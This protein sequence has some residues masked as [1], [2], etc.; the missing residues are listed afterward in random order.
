M[1]HRGYDVMI[2]FDR[3]FRYYLNVF[4]IKSYKKSTLMYT[5]L[6]PAVYN[7]ASLFDQE[8]NGHNGGAIFNDCRKNKTKPMTYQ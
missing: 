2:A 5:E 7:Y 1:R 3:C 6:L 4:D 8:M